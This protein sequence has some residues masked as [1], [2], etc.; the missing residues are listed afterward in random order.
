MAEISAQALM[1]AIKA[2]HAMAARLEDESRSAE[3]DYAVQQEL[4]DVSAAETE[5]RKLYEAMQ[6]ESD[7]LPLYS[8]LVEAG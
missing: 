3:D 6:R 1:V 4:L 5:L 7:N 8:R 2:V